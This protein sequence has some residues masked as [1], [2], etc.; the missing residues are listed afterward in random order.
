MEQ[1]IPYG[2]AKEAGRSGRG[3]QSAGLNGAD[4]RATGLDS[5]NF[6]GIRNRG[7]ESES[8]TRKG[9][10]SQKPPPLFL[11][12]AARMCVAVCC[13]ERNGSFN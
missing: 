8:C 5:L 4:E 2:L 1:L 11:W 13:L 12:V 10:A 9:W 3:P 7:R 6:V